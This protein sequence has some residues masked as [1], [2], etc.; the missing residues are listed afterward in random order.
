[1]FL[2]FGVRFVS[3][4]SEISREDSNYLNRVQKNARNLTF[5]IV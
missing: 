5:F 1:M 4:S 3:I 2:Y